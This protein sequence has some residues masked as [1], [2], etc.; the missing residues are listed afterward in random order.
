MDKVYKTIG[1]ITKKQEWKEDDLLFS[2]FT[3]DFRTYFK[4]QLD[5]KA[6]VFD[7]LE[8]VENWECF[9]GKENIKI[10]IYNIHSFFGGNIFHDFL[11]RIGVK[12]HSSFQK[13]KEEVNIKS[14]YPEV[15]VAQ[16]ISL[17]RIQVER[18]EYSELIKVAVDNTPSELMKMNYRILD[19]SDIEFVRKLFAESNRKLALKYFGEGKSL[20]ILNDDFKKKKH[21]KELPQIN[22]DKILFSAIEKLDIN[23]S[24]DVDF[25]RD[26][27]LRLEA[28]DLNMAYKLMSLAYQARPHGPLIKAKYHEYKARINVPA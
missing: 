8:F 6:I 10:A 25:L 12:W 22:V 28:T 20:F 23:Y 27:A 18:S 19:E 13:P 11:S 24:F 16:E 17:K 9:F 4:Q 5:A 2:I 1:Y 26:E 14:S 15:L 21:I 3:K 7:Y